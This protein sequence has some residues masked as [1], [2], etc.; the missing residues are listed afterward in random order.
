MLKD[1]KPTRLA[2][3]GNKETIE[4]QRSID[5]R[6]AVVFMSIPK[7]CWVHKSPKIAALLLA[8]TT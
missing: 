1:V 5:F 8:I 3:R 2:D 6:V 4:R 7:G